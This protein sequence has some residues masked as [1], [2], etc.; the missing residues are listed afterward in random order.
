MS[1]TVVSAPLDREEQLRRNLGT[2]GVRALPDPKFP[3]ADLAVR[4]RGIRRPASKVDVLL[5]NPPTPDGAV[6]IRS[7]HR[8]GRR[9]RENMIWPQMELAQMAAILEADYSVAIIDANAER[10]GWREF[11]KRLAE[12]R[13]RY[14]LTQVT[15]PTL[16]ND[17]YGCFLARSFGAVTLAFGTHVTPMPR[18]TL[19]QFP[20]LDFVLRGEPEL[21]LRELLDTLQLTSGVWSLRDGALVQASGAPADADGRWARILADADP[22]W[23]P[24]WTISGDA[25]TQDTRIAASHEQLAAVKGLA[26]RRVHEVIVNPDRPFVRN[27]DDLPIPRHD[28]LPYDKYRIPMIRGPYT[29]VVTS[30][31]CTAGCKYCIKHVSYQYSVRLRSAE[32][33]LEELWALK[34]L[35]IAH[36]HMYAD[37]FTVNREQVMQICRLMIEQKIELSWT[38]NSRVDYVDQ[39]M[40]QQMAQAGC[41]LISWGIESASEQILRR[42]AKGYRM[43]QA[44]RALEWA[45]A[46]GIRNW[47]YFIIGLPG[48]TVD[49]I[50][51]TI[52]FAK[53]LPLDVALFHVAAPYPGTPFFF[54]VLEN[55]WFR[56]G[57]QWEQ[58]DMDK[59]TVLDYPGLGAEQ[60]EYWQKRAFREW[61]FRPGPALTFLRSINGPQVLRSALEIALGSVRW[62]LGRSEA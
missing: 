30:R 50:Q 11:E 62:A 28:L 42:A 25:C 32:N 24:A 34:K 45:H 17:M 44:P 22:E 49:T 38:C 8:V 31:G 9:S 37:L 59:G 23:R 18:E 14:Y 51:E 36:V 7:Q 46:V 57:T 40:L 10:M 21:T 53:A 55:G 56:A 12:L 16:T 43:E 4:R 2:R 15:A 48:E 41:T 26:W 39:E 58:V 52:R 27:L 60:L 5:V 6:W 3:D 1:N 35:G 61:A 47:G 19:E 13:P 33:V 29:F 54:D 20:A